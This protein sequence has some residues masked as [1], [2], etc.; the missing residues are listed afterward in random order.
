MA[1]KRVIKGDYEVGYGKPPV[2]TRFK[3]GDPSRNPSGRPRREPSTLEMYDEELRAKLEVT[4]GGR[5]R[6]LAKKRLIVKQQVNQ[7]LKGESAALKQVTSI[8]AALDA[9]AASRVEPMSAKERAAVD[10]AILDQIY[11]QLGSGS[12]GEAAT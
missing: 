10:R 2:A 6:R 9:L 3:A 11:D 12:E 1:K 5:K 8:M 7:A 4:E